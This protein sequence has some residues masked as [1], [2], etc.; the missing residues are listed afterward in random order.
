ML[1]APPLVIL[2]FGMAARSFYG[3]AV[4]HDALDVYRVIHLT[5]SASSVAYWLLFSIAAGFV[6]LGVLLLLALLQGKRNVVLTPTYISVPRFSLRGVEHTA[7]PYSS[8]QRLE[9]FQA[10][11]GTFLNIRHRHGASTLAKAAF[12]SESEFQ[13]VHAALMAQSRG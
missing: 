6:V 7:I 13:S 11:N 12:K 1:W 9:L 2:F 3:S 5:G 8:I 10:G 4:R